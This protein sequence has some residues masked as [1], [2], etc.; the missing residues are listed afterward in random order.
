MTIIPPSI[1]APLSRTLASCEPGPTMEPLISTFPSPGFYAKF[2]VFFFLLLSL[3]YCIDSLITVLQEDILASLKVPLKKSHFFLVQIQ[4][5]ISVRIS[6]VLFGFLPKSVSSLCI[7][8]VSSVFGCFLRVCFGF[9][10][11]RGGSPCGR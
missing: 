1:L 3:N 8:F 4:S 9:R 11:R 6:T 5:F 2:W 7:V 10:V